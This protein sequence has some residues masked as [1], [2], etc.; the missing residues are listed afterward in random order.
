[1]TIDCHLHICP[2]VGGTDGRLPY[3]GRV[4]G[5][6]QSAYTLLRDRFADAVSTEDMNAALARVKAKAE[7]KF[8]KEPRETDAGAWPRR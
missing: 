2:R 3:Q 7:G 1:V 6:A 8:E 5:K 4:Y